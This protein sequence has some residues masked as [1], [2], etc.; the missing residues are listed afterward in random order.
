MAIQLPVAPPVHEAYR[1]ADQR[2]RRCTYRRLNVVQSGSER[3]YEAECLYPERRLPI[4]LGDLES[5]TPVCNACT[6]AHIFRADED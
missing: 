3:I 5:A 6:A 4:P 2:I 1:L